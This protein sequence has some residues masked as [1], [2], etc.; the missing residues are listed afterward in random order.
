MSNANIK[1]KDAS[2]STFTEPNPT[3]EDEEIFKDLPEGV[4]MHAGFMGRQREYVVI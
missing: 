3:Q 2:D 4:K 1:P